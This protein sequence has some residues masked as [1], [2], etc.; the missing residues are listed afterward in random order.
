MLSENEP[1][2]DYM[3]WYFLNK[4]KYESVM[5]NVSELIKK[6]LSI[7]ERQ[8]Y[9]IKTRVKSPEGFLKKVY[10]GQDSYGNPSYRNPSQIVDLAGIR[11]IAYLASELKDIY[12][13]VSSAVSIIEVREK[14]NERGY[15]AKHIIA[16]LS[17]QRKDLPEYE[18]IKDIQFEI[19]FKTIL[20]HAWAEIEHDRIYK[21]EGDVPP[22]IPKKFSNLAT[23]LLKIDKTFQDISDTIETG[24]KEILSNIKQG[25]LNIPIDAISLK[26]YVN[27]KFGDLPTVKLLYGVLGTK[28]ILEELKTMGIRTLSDLD[29]ITSPRLR[30]AYI[31]LGKYSG[32]RDNISSVVRHIL[33]VYDSKRYFQ[34][35]WKSH[36]LV[37]NPDALYVLERSG[38]DIDEIKKHLTIRSH[39][40]G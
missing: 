4:P 3:E 15:N 33:M 14:H 5:E 9:E 29:N 38:A 31:E 11:I 30:D 27:V 21:Y 10:Q 1:I 16:T 34:K 6:L 2:V 8:Y 18:K 19:Q 20:Q 40:F 25:I 35:A 22:G 32:L 7:H 39:G 36:F 24:P 13:L 23:K 26:Q 28:T 37:M 12:D 17:E